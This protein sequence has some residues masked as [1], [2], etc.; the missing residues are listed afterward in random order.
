MSVSPVE[1]YGERDDSLQQ[2]VPKEAFQGIEDLEGYFARYLPQAVLASIVPLVVIAGVAIVDLEAALIMVVTLPLV[3]VFMWLIG[4]YTE[5]RTRERWQALRQLSLQF[6]DVVRGLETLR[7]YRRGPAQVE[8]IEQHTDEFRRGTMATLRVAFLSAFVLELAA[9]LGTAL[10]AVEIG[11][12]FLER[13]GIDAIHGHVQALT[14]D[15]LEPLSEVHGLDDDGFAVPRTHRRIFDFSRDGIRRSFADSLARLGVDV[16]EAGFPIA[17]QGD[18]ESVQRI[19]E[20]IKGPVITGLARSGREDIVRAGEAVKPAE[21]KRIHAF[22]STSPLHMKYKLRME[23]EAVLEAV[24]RS[25][26]LA[27]DFTDDVEWS[28]EDGS[29]TEP[30]FLCRCVETAIAA[31]ATTINIPDTVGYAI[32]TEFEAFVR[33]V[34]E[35]VPGIEKTRVSVHCHNDLGMATANSLAGVLGGAEQVPPGTVGAAGAAG[36]LA[37]YR[38]RPQPVAGG[39]EALREKQVVLI[40]RVNVGHSPAVPQDFHR[41]VQAGQ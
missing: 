14:G 10:V 23:P 12:R 37:I 9:S 16:I 35:K 3:P 13:Q 31:G 15:L 17:S 22:I 40:L 20:T 11:I 41:F 1:G 27:R 21:R 5:E 28:A 6:L 19:A 38:D 33:S 26:T 7:A 18:F 24:T 32:P 36:G 2:V 29:R 8:S 4:T 39:D 30:D 34:M 25:V